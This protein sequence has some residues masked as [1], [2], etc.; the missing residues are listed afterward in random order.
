[1]IDSEASATTKD[2]LSCLRFL[3]IRDPNW[4]IG[5]YFIDL[6][7]YQQ[8][9]AVAR[10][11]TINPVHSVVEA[12]RRKPRSEAPTR[13]RFDFDRD[14][15]SKDTNKMGYNIVRIEC[16]DSDNPFEVQLHKEIDYDPAAKWSRAEISSW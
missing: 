2:F 6:V 14:V 3:S 13:F 12:A 8:M 4:Q 15:V 1:M 10:V 16:L 5:Q 11:R 9:V 7:E